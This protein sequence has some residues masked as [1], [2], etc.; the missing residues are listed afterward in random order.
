MFE[1]EAERIVE[2]EYD[3]CDVTVADKTLSIDEQIRKIGFQG[4]KQAIVTA[5]KEDSVDN[6]DSLDASVHETKEETAAVAAGTPTSPSHVQQPTSPTNFPTTPTPNEEESSSDY[7]TVMRLLEEGEKI[8]HMY[9]ASRIQGLDTAEGLM[10]FGKEHFY[11]LDGFTLINGREVHDIDFIPQ[12]HFEPIIPVV[13]GQVV[14]SHL[15]NQ[16]LQ[17]I[18]SFF[19]RCPV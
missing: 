7:Q 10:L 15:Q 4:L 16:I 18:P 9:R 17:F 14:E 6:E 5:A 13:P 3:D 8:T 19:S 2:M 12:T 1:R 11:I